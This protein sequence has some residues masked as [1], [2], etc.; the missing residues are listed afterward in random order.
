MTDKQREAYEQRLLE[1]RQEALE[2]VGDFDD[3][4]R[5]ELGDHDGELSNYP[6][7]IADDGTDTMDQEKEFLLASQEGRRLYAIDEALRRL[8]KRPD[9]FGSCV[10]CGR[11]ISEERLDLIPWTATCSEH[12]EQDPTARPNE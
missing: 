10:E 11:E 2:A 3:R 8:Y 7:H 1:E 12:A 9:E 4:A 5:N 6:L